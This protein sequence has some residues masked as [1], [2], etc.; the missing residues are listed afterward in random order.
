MPRKSLKADDPSVDVPEPGTPIVDEGPKAQPAPRVQKP[1]H[2]TVLME[3]RWLNGRYPKI[4]AKGIR[5]HHGTAVVDKET[6]AAAKEHPLF[7]IEFGKYGDLDDPA[8]F[9][10]T[11]VVKGAVHT[12]T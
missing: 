9:R 6:F 3:C 4:G 10:A 8:I 12:R 5:F 11:K 7:G 1:S 2:S